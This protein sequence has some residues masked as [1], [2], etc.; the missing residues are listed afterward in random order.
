MLESPARQRSRYDY[1]V[2]IADFEGV[3]MDLWVTPPSPSPTLFRFL[4]ILF[5]IL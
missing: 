2:K 4:L 5:L 1:E 3:L